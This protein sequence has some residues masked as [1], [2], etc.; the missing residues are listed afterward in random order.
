MQ[1][2]KNSRDVCTVYV[3]QTNTHTHGDPSGMRKMPVTLY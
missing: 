3:A 1:T 2:I